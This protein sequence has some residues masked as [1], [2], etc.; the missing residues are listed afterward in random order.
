MNVALKQMKQIMTRMVKGELGVRVMIWKSSIVDFKLEQEMD[1]IQTK[2]R[3]VVDALQ[4]HHFEQQQEHEG[5][6]FEAK[7]AS[8]NVALKQMKQIMTRMVRG[9]VGVRV[10]IWK[11]LIVDFKLEQEEKKQKE[12]AA[13]LRGQKRQ[14]ESL[15]EQL[16]ASQSQRFDDSVLS[17]IQSEHQA[18]VTELKRKLADSLAESFEAQMSKM[19]IDV[20]HE[21]ALQLREDAKTQLKQQHE[22]DINRKDTNH[23]DQMQ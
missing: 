21:E 2:H 13:A 4:L 1:E 16:A 17:K 9:E 6:K 20:K 7:S 15:T 11:S 3:K 10:M 14:M 12:V 23:A 22:A 8:M 19:N 18:E 5:S